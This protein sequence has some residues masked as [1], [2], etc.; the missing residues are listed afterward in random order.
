LRW[1]IWCSARQDRQNSWR[2]NEG[3]LAGRWDRVQYQNQEVHEEVHIWIVWDASLMHEPRTLIVETERM[4]MKMVVP[5]LPSTE[6][7]Y[8]YKSARPQTMPQPLGRRPG[9]KQRVQKKH[10]SRE[11][12]SYIKLE[13]NSCCCGVINFRMLYRKYSCILL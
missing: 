7:L 9:I 10:R 8:G 11:T 2:A 1:K 13:E 12:V 5:Q 6:P 3:P 4:L